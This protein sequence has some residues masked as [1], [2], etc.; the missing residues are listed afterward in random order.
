MRAVQD[1]CLVF[2]LCLPLVFLLSCER[3]SEAEEAMEEVGEAF[4]EV[5]DDIKDATN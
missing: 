3:E 2:F 1:I 5:G 4:E